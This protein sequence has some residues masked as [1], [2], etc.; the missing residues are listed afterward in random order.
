[1]MKVTIRRK[2]VAYH[3]VEIVNDRPAY[4][5]FFVIDKNHLQ[6]KFCKF[7]ISARRMSIVKVT[8]KRD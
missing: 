2:M 4:K 5:N 8:I 1:M 6:Q 7:L 3:M